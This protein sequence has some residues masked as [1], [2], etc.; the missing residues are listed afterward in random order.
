M[1][2]LRFYC[3]V[4]KTTKLKCLEKS[5]FFQQQRRLFFLQEPC[6]RKR[7]QVYCAIWKHNSLLFLQFLLENFFASKQLNEIFVYFEK[8][9]PIYYKGAIHMHHVKTA[10]IEETLSRAICWR[11][12]RHVSLWK[13]MED[14]QIQTLSRTFGQCLFLYRKLRIPI[15]LFLKVFDVYL[16]ISERND[17]FF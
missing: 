2:I 3:S 17:N 10:S 13:T 4:R 14:G 8:Y 1:N 11:I 15:M 5:N 6:Y 7:T 12:R 9:F 16:V